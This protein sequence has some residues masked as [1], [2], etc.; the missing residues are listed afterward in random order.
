M[1][2]ILEKTNLTFIFVMSCFIFAVG[3]VIMVQPWYEETE[4]STSAVSGVHHRQISLTEQ[5]L[6]LLGRFPSFSENCAF[7]LLSFVFKTCVF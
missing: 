1:E 6:H 2:S 7:S 5:L 3:V 4:S